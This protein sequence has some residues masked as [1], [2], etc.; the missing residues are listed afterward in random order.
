MSADR[1]RQEQALSAAWDRMLS[2]R[3][4]DGADV[5]PGL[6]ETLHQIV[7]LEARAPISGEL[8]GS[9]WTNVIAGTGELWRPG[10]DSLRAG[11]T[12]IGA[13]S[14][15]GILAP[16]ADRLTHFAWIIA[17][18]FIGGFIAGV[19]SRLFMRLAGFLTPDQNRF[20]LTE[21][22]ARV[23]EITLGGT[24]SLGLLGAGAGVVTVLIYL[25]IRGRLPFDGWRR[26]SV[27]AILLLLVFGYVIMD[28][29]NPDYQLFGPTWLNVSTFSSLYLLMGF[30]CGQTYELGNRYSTRIV[31][32][33]Q[34]LVIRIPLLLLSAMACLF[35]LFMVMIA[36]FVGAAGLIVLAVAG[37]AWLADRYLKLDRVL[38]Y[39]MPDL[40][41][42]WGT[43]VVPGITGFI[44]TARGI[45]E[46]LLNR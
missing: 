22:E 43:L 33:R 17:A 27:F 30:C 16:I 9:I 24:I 42:P 46:I 7:A 11:E 5:D 31:S 13:A 35:G 45:T 4:A 20:R 3:S 29:S 21:N 1:N 37:L 10:S 34:R 38:S 8:E 41:R 25:A 40:I 14:K 19:G 2:G 28:P 12:T 6:V 44:L 23:G 26:S 18:G 32:A 39:R 36:M 15:P